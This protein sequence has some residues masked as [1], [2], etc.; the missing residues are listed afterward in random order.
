M[1]TEEGKQA[2]AKSRQQKKQHEKKGFFRNLST[3]AGILCLKRVTLMSQR[4]ASHNL[5][6]RKEITKFIYDFPGKKR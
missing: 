3:Q 6:Q 5:L 4:E 1:P 2:D